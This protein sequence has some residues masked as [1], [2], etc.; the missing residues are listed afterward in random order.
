VIIK[1]PLNVEFSQYVDQFMSKY[2][3]IIYNQDPPRI[4]PE[5]KKLLQ[6]SPYIR[7]RY[8]YV[9]ENYTKIR[10]YGCQLAPFC[11]S[12]FMT[13]TICFLEYIR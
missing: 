9:F 8:W 13:P 7:V 4:F 3:Q 5:C 10:I 12:I 1:K 11:L 2:Y 6:L